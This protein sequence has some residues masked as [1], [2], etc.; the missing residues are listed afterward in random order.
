MILVQFV[1]LYIFY[2]N[3]WDNMSRNMAKSL[4]GEIS[5][6]VNALK[7]VEGDK[8]QE[9][10]ILLA[11]R[12][13]MN[14]RT[15]FEPKTSE[16]KTGDFTNQ[17]DL[18]N[19]TLTERVKSPFSIEAID[20][21]DLMVKVDIGGRILKFSFSKKRVASPTTY[22]FIMWVI[23]TSLLM[24]IVAILFLRGQ[25]R[26]ILELSHAA[27][28]FGKGQEIANYKPAGAKEI[29]LAAIAFI[30]MKERIKRLLDTRTQML[31]GVSHDLKTPL[32]RI[33]LQLSL[34]KKKPKEISAIEDDIDEMKR[35]IE[36]YLG[37][38]QIDSTTEFKEETKEVNLKDFINKIISKYKNQKA[39]FHENISENIYL[40]IKPEYFKR[41]ITNLFDNAA[42]YGKNIY[43]NS[44]VLSDKELEISIDDDGVGI[45]ESMWDRVFQPFYRV[46]SSRNQ[47]TG[48][49]GLGLTIARDIIHKHGGSITLSNGEHGGLK[50]VI[51]L[52]V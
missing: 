24:C 17:Y 2:E 23:G 25:V 30:E 14:L 27:E 46:E 18:L 4:T 3:H 7:N 11:S 26:S 42:R 9:D 43:I 21:S 35:M 20:E 8:S 28:K 31:A 44:Q 50:A 33:K 12:S 1:T 13:Y 32:T 52:P 48:G 37:F 38:A 5:L 29:R 15:E 49:V 34:I 6:I 36:G 51:V 45:P 22:I 41:S 10:Y 47:D 19:N 40:H 16:M 39:I